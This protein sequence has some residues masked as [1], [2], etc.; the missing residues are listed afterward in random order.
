MLNSWVECGIMQSCIRIFST[1]SGWIAANIHV[2]YKTV[3]SRQ[4]AGQIEILL[5]YKLTSD[6]NSTNRFACRNWTG[7]MWIRCSRAIYLSCLFA[8]DETSVTKLSCSELPSFVPVPAL[9]YISSILPDHRRVRPTTRGLQAK[10]Q[11]NFTCH[12]K[13]THRTAARPPLPG[14]HTSARLD[15]CASYYLFSSP[16]VFAP[17]ACMSHPVLKI[18]PSVHCMCAMIKFPTYSK[19]RW[20]TDTVSRIKDK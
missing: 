19:Q 17:E 1:Y 11:R 8:E 10:D 3:R 9:A 13:P 2:A 12:R 20:I 4:D 5:E 15:S 14:V 16:V 7:W 18:K 6:H